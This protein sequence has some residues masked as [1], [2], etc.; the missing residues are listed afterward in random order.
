[1]DTFKS[2]QKAMLFVAAFTF[3][4]HIHAST[5]QN[6]YSVDTSHRAK[7][8]I[9]KQDPEVKSLGIRTILIPTALQA[10]PKDYYIANRQDI[11]KPNKDGDFLF[12]PDTAEFDATHTFA[13]VWN[14]LHMYRQDMEYLSKTYPHNESYHQAIKH[15]DS[16]KYGKLSIYPKS[17][18]DDQNAFY[19]RSLDKLGRPIRELRFFSFDGEKGRVHTCQSL[20]IVAHETGHAVLD[21]LHPE[22]FDTYAT[23]VG[24]FHESFGDITAIFTA[25]N[26]AD[27]C[28]ALYAET[29]GDLGQPS[30]LTEVAEQFGTGLGSS[31]GL[32]NLLDDVHM[33]TTDQEVHAISRVFTNSIYG[34]LKD[35]FRE[36]DV[37]FG[38]QTTGAE[39]LYDVGKFLRRLFL[40]SV[41]EL[42]KPEPTYSDF[43]YK[44]YDLA[45]HQAK[46]DDPITQLNW[47]THI[48]NNFTAKGIP[49]E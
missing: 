44:L 19:N 33:K 36:A 1:M 27:I 6:E 15:W 23:M 47:A 10:G 26:Q 37:S 21:I 4:S 9:Y 48:M 3:H 7:M 5:L 35:A 29:R 41:I 25:L 40:A 49:V 38:Y 30:F 39:Q 11:A 12:A 31:T 42:K 13:V 43:A 22:Y 14:T 18:P 2:I 28:E 20:D 16:R 24:G 46:N 8:Q 32:R 34:V 45:L 17:Q